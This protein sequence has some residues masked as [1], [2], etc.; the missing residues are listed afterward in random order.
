V[1]DSLHKPVTGAEVHLQ[2][3]NDHK[4]L[5][6]LTDAKGAFKF[7]ALRE[8]T[9][10]LR[11]EMRGIGK[12][13]ASSVIL[14]ENET[15]TV[16]LTLSPEELSFFDEPTFSVAGVTDTT[17]LGG[18]GSDTVIRTKEALAKATVSL[19]ASS[20]PP[21]TTRTEHEEALRAR[22]KREPEN[23]EANQ[24]LGR[25]L[26]DNGKPRDAVPYLE[27][28]ARIHP[29]DYD[30]AY[31]LGLALANSGDYEQARANVHALLAKQ[32]NAELHHL[33]GD[34]AEKTGDPL[35]AVREYQRAAQ[36][37]PSESNLFDWGAELLMHHAPEP[38]AEVFSKA[39]R[40]FPHSVRLLLGLGVAWFVHG[41]YDLA[42]QYLG[43]ASDLHPDDPMPYLFLGK[44]QSIEASSP[45]ITERLARFVRLQPENGLATYYYAVSLWKQ[46]KG[47][48]TQTATR[49][50]SLLEKAIALDPKL[51]EAHLQLGILYSEEKD[52]PR[53]IA[54][55]QQAITVNPK[56]EQAH[57]CLA[58]TYRRIGQSDK[59]QNE[60]RLY[61][62]LSKETT[63]EMERERSAI[64]QFVYTLREDK[65][66]SPR[67]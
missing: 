44:I 25:L 16:D 67:P 42:V 50:K 21:S 5:N 24:Q 40:A 10:S 54:A 58:Q 3:H 48:D 34:V 13:A 27:A 18:H 19:S 28:A 60:L 45:A 1:R 49:V 59:V 36:L 53:A 62:Q 12:A 30:N 26:V 6:T 43:E 41:S 14:K 66:S 38:A 15:R 57:Y 33:L 51:G 9:Y 32:D 23:F 55:Y 31:E 2:C 8:G 46:R 29:G 11:A 61:E 39:H 4:I 7:S 47:P 52:F 17:S 35:E 22:L 37:N 64:K 20:S 65:N 56:M 63:V